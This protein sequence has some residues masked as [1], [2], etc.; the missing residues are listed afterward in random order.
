[1]GRSRA[2]D[3]ITGPF[4][5]GSL[6][7]G[8]GERVTAQLRRMSHRR[9]AGKPLSPRLA[10]AE[11]DGEHLALQR[12][13]VVCGTRRKSC[14]G[15]RAGQTFVQGA[16]TSGWTLSCSAEL[17]RERR[18][19]LFDSLPDPVLRQGSAQ[20]SQRARCG[21][22]CGLEAA[23]QKATAG[24]HELKTG[25]WRRERD[26]NPRYG[27]PYTHFPGV[28]L[29][30][31]GHPSSAESF[32]VCNLVRICANRMRFPASLRSAPV[33]PKRCKRQDRTEESL[34]GVTLRQP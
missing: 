22:R 2:A 17:T 13:M 34:G 1:M 20:A 19:G 11:I 4:A 9:R 7:E 31:L 12:P 25:E 26:S 16:R 15:P 33:A 32:Q 8:D 3:S 30:P 21:T 24:F 29:Q 10:R 23:R 28:R 27:F 5:A 6:G 14:T 18:T